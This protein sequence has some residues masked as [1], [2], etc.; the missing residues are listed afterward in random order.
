MIG[1]PEGA[2]KV[3]DVPASKDRARRTYDSI[4][5]TWEE[6]IPCATVEANSEAPATCIEHFSK[7]NL[8]A[9]AVHM[10]FYQHHPLILSPDAV[11]TTIAQ[12]VAFHVNQN[13]DKLRSKFVSH[14]G[15][16]EISIVRPEFKK[17]CKENDWP[18]VFPEF[19]E[20]IKK[21]THGDIHDVIVSDFSTTTELSKLCSQITLM[22]CMKSYFEYTMY[23]GCGIPYIQLTGTTEDWLNIRERINKFDDYDLQ[24]WT[25]E[26]APVLDHFVKAS[27]GDPD[28]H[29]WQ[30]INN[31]HGASGIRKPITGWIQVFFPY[32]TEQ[33]ERGS[34]S[35]AQSANIKM[36]RNP[37][38][39]EWRKTFENPQAAKDLDRGFGRGRDCGA[40]IN[41][42]QIPS[43][44]SSAPF[45]FKDVATDEQWSMGFYGGLTCLTQD[46]ETGALEPQ[47]GWAVLDHSEK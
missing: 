1:L 41:L 12:G 42:K 44:I 33:H 19:A 18:G 24:F 47:F 22:D 30:S 31:L 5:D 14:E 27:K 26:L 36:L 2:F 11:W 39:G 37:Y 6:E 10:A 9:K 43:G 34:I 8:L 40:G 17:G 16:E 46:P 3:Q 23:C 20:K 21:K 7:N 25:Q 15:K 35:Q 38:L 32:L 45:T 28:I 4:A 29:F 13:A